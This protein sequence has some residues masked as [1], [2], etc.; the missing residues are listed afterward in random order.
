ML[1]TA[2]G[3]V[4]ARLLRMPSL[5]V[6]GKPVHGLSVAVTAIPGLDSVDGLLGMD[7]LSHFAFTIDDGAERLLLV[8]R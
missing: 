7:Y 3:T 6:G 8:P 5:A 4:K 2:G 1:Q